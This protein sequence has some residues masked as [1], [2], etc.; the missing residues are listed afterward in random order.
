MLAVT[1]DSHNMVGE[2]LATGRPV[3]AIRP[4]KLKPKLGSF[5]RHMEE[6]K[7]LRQFTKTIEHYDCQPVDATQEIADAIIARA[8]S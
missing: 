5:L 7:L 6:R 8:G 2:A 3:Y 1:A 4:M